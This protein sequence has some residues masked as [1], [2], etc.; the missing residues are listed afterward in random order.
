MAEILKHLHIE[1]KTRKHDAVYLPQ[2]SKVNYVS[3]SKNSRNANMV[4]DM[5]LV[6]MV[7]KG[8]ESLETGMITKLNITM[9]NKSHNWCLD[10]GAT[11]YV[12]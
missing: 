8:I 3:E 10:S 9:T 7:M 11:V 6:A 5:D 12:L 1:E 4:E 2:S